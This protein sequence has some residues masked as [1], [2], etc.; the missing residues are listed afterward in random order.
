MH[1]FPLTFQVPEEKALTKIRK[2]PYN[3]SVCGIVMR[4]KRLSVKQRIHIVIGPRLTKSLSYV[5]SNDY[6]SPFISSLRVTSAFT[7]SVNEKL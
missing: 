3:M 4:A 1:L 2:V 7:L 5:A 6:Q